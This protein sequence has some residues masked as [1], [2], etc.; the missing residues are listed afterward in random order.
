ML[1][2]RFFV[3]VILA[4]AAALSGCASSGVPKGYTGPVAKVSDSLN[5]RS[6]SQVEIFMV[7]KVNDRFVQNTEQATAMANQG[8]GLGYAATKVIERDIPAQP[9]K[10]KL[11][12][13]TRYAS[14]MQALFGQNYEVAGE[15]LLQARPN[16]QYVVNGELTKARQA[17]W[18]EDKATGKIVTQVVTGRR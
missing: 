2:T 18:V 15:V 14:D 11:I 7:T 10:L 5:H 4:A 9:V 6:A 16:A 12:G 1:S 17:V 8:M 3:P 13:R